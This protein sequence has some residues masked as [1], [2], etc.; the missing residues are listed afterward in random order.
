MPDWYP[1]FIKLKGKKVLV[2]GGGTVATR[3]VKKLINYYPEI[4]IVSPK[5]TTELQRLISKHNLKYSQR[6][7]RKSDLKNK[8]IIFVATDDKDL[9]KQISQDAKKSGIL[10]NVV[11]NPAYCSFIVPSVITRGDLQIAIS[12]SGIS[13][14]LTKTLRK[15]IENLFGNEYITLLKLIKKY[16]KVILDK[17]KDNKIKRKKLEELLKPSILNKIK[18]GDIR[19]AENELKKIIEENKKTTP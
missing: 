19:Q 14:L 16:R 7:Y 11:D 5:I 1:I 2:V 10:I 15:K 17:F 9:N 18:N 13:P 4:T 8:W 3:K 6:N 12:T